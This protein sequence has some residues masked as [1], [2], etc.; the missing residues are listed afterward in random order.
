MKPRPVVSRVRAAGVDHQVS[1]VVGGAGTYRRWPCDGC[2]WRMDQTGAFPAE[3]FAHSAETA[4]DLSTHTFACH[5]A[6]T[7]Q[8][9]I[10]A[11]FLLRGAD[12]NLAIRMRAADGRID[13]AAVRDGG[14]ELHRDYRGMAVANGLDPMHPALAQCRD[15]H[16]AA[17][18]NGARP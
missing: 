6:G 3:A 9:A 16:P 10:C 4:H 14:H 13:L 2:P 1:T 5:E 17:H 15:A 18:E 8:P 11:G 12:H 7:E